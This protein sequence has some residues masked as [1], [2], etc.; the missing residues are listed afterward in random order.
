MSGLLSVIIGGVIT[1]VG[2]VL[3]I[4]W[5]YEFFFV[6]RAGIPIILVICGIISVIAGMSEM[7]DREKSA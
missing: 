5:N 2:I 6:L 3:F 7:K 1:L 4:M